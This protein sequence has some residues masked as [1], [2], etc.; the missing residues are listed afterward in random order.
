MKKSKNV[1]IPQEGYA[2]RYSYLGVANPHDTSSSPIQGLFLLYL[3]PTF[4]FIISG[5]WLPLLSVSLRVYAKAFDKIKAGAYLPFVS[6]VPRVSIIYRCNKYPIH[7]S[8][9][10]VGFNI[11]YIDNFTTAFYFIDTFYYYI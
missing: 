10:T 9:I 8:I 11:F 2:T 4:S 6:P 5:V 1:A 3:L 7:S